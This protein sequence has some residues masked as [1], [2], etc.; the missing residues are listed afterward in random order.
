MAVSFRWRRVRALTLI[1]LVAVVVVAALL[2][3]VAA[4]GF[5]QVTSTARRSAVAAELRDVARAA[6]ALHLFGD[7]WDVAVAAAAAEAGRSAPGAYASDG[8]TSRWQILD[9]GV[10]PVDGNEL[11]WLAIGDVAA[12]TSTVDGAGVAVV[13]SGGGRS[14][15]SDDADPV[16]ALSTAG[17]VLDAVASVASVAVPQGLTVSWLANDALSYTVTVQPGGASCTSTA[18]SCTVGGLTDGVRYT[19]SVQ[20]FVGSAPVGPAAVGPSRAAGAPGN[21][22]VDQANPVVSGSLLSSTVSATVEVDEVAL[23]SAGTRSVWFRYVNDTAVPQ[24]LS[25]AGSDPTGQP[26]RHTREV[27]VAGVG[28]PLTAAERVSSGSIAERDVAVI[29]PGQ[30]AWVRH[31]SAQVGAVTLQFTVVPLAVNDDVASATVVDAVGVTAHTLNLWG[32]TASLGDGARDVWWRVSNPSLADRVAVLTGTASHFAA[33]TLFTGPGEESLTLVAG[34]STFHGPQVRVVSAG[35]SLWARHYNTSFALGPY[36]LSF[37]LSERLANDD[38]VSATALA[39][40]TSGTVN[41]FGASAE[42]GELNVSA[43]SRTAWWRYTNASEVPRTLRAGRGSGTHL[44]EQQIFRGDVG[45]LVSAA[46]GN[47][48]AG[49]SAVVA[50]GETVWLR[51]ATTSTSSTVAAVS[52]NFTVE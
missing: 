32:A 47:Q 52:Y 10:V 18:M 6:A 21:D 27:F 12:L 11:G 26:W 16:S 25:T 36:S 5:G 43:T 39:G 48:N 49:P 29:P 17:F 37:R 14:W 51:L 38:V 40:S 41:L 50:P 9:A 24:V 13:I 8:Q 20:A 4:V 30:S 31:S 33:V 28:A 35:E 22:D 7:P 2:T 44:V 23:P 42:V 15:E 45:S 46:A 34:P 3:S 19:P 1:E